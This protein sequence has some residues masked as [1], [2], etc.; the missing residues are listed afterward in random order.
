MKQKTRKC[1]HCHDQYKPQLFNGIIKSVYCRKCLVLLN[2]QKRE[3]KRE[4]KKL[5]V[6]KKKE[7]KIN[8]KKYQKNLY[9][10]THDKAWKLMRE[11][12]WLVLFG[13]TEYGKCY[14]CNKVIDKSGHLSHFHHSKLDFDLRNLKYCCS[15]CNTY[16]SGN[17]NIYATKL[18]KEL[19]V[20]G[21]QKLLL[22]AN[23]TIYR[24]EDLQEVISRLEEKIQYYKDKLK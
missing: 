1:R 2:R 23:T 7:R 20:E 9:R 24:L 19:G 16:K 10:R 17:L 6:V 5:K 18:V 22:D 14:T 21:M 4:E 13:D 8:S 3:K 12:V 11:Y 15:A